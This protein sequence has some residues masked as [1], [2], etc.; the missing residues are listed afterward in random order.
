MELVTPDCGTLQMKLFCSKSIIIATLSH[1]IVVY[2]YLKVPISK[3]EEMLWC[4]LLCP[5]GETHVRL[6]VY[7]FVS[8]FSYNI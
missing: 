2:E 4:F 1:C 7:L 8:G 6:S 3:P 5:F